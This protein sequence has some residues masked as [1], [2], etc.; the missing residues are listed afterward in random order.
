MSNQTTTAKAQF[1]VLK[2]TLKVTAMLL[3]RVLFAD[4]N[5]VW[6]TKEAPCFHCQLLCYCSY[7]QFGEG[8]CRGLAESGVRKRSM[9]DNVR[10]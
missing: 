10:R 4:K 2:T 9:I 5:S 3:R 8:P 7:C 1:L 6:K